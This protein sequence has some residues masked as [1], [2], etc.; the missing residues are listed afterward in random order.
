MRWKLFALTL[1]SCIL[2]PLA[3]PNEIFLDGNPFLGLFCL[4]FLF[5]ALYEAPTF[6]FAALMGALFGLAT[7]LF[8]NIWLK[9]YNEYALYTLGG[10][11]IAYMGYNALL[12]AIIHGF[13]KMRAARRPF[14]TAAVFCVYEYLKSTG[15]LGFPY[16]LVSQPVHSILPFVQFVDITGQW[17]LSF[18]CA[19]FSS[20]LAEAFVFRFNLSHGRG[21]VWNSLA[22]MQYRRSIGLRWKGLL[23]LALTV[24][25][26]AY[27]GLRL[28]TGCPS[29]K[30]FLALLVQQDIDPWRRDQAEEGLDIAS[31]ITIRGLNDSLGRYKRLPDLVVWSETALRY[32]VDVRRGLPFRENPFYGKDH[33]DLFERFRTTT[34]TG[35]AVYA[36]QPN[37]FYNA[38]I[39]VTKDGR[40]PQFYAKQHPVPFV[41]SIPFM[42][43]KPLR[44]W[45]ER[46]LG[47]TNVWTIGAKP[48]T[49]NLPLGDG[50]TVGFGVPICFEDVYADVCRGMV[51]D[52][53][54]A[55]INI[56]NDSWSGMNSALTQHTAAA[57]YRA[58]ETRTPLLRST[59]AGLTCV[60][61]PTGA[62]RT[63]PPLFQPG[64]LLAEVP[65]RSGSLV[66]LYA[67]LGDYFPYLLA[68]WLL[69]ELLLNAYGPAWR[70]ALMA[71]IASRQRKPSE[72]K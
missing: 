24:I 29:G 36:P 59:N 22:R 28:A 16:S 61:D 25:A 26:F 38:A 50:R 34:L 55:L 17:G 15:F 32:P 70:R 67:L 12:G 14:F 33:P 63:G 54:E 41:E 68:A 19:L 30:S 72:K 47:L 48:V 51:R 37:H 6:R 43:I 23:V 35:A 46:D 71:V 39:L 9:N 66:T 45:F 58:I 7:C 10:T 11:A 40:V 69:I 27:G 2:F 53:A 31:A 3:L 65:V 1:L 52:G 64:Y 20:L 5:W 56:S 57:R 8:S 4:S 62:I 18:F 13:S 44:D 60:I 21:G 42:E 49:F